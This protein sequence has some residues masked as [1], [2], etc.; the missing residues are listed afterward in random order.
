MRA[1]ARRRALFVQ[2]PPISPDGLPARENHPLGA[3]CVI[4]SALR[5]ERG[6]G[7]E[8][9]ILDRAVADEGSD[10]AILD[11]IERWRPGIL[12]V[13]LYVWNVVR[14]IHMIREARK[15]I[16]D[17]LVV[18]GGP[19]AVAGRPELF[20][21][22]IDIAVPGEG[23][24]AFRAVLEA[25]GAG[26]AGASL[27]RVPGLLLPPP[28]PGAAP[29]FTGP[30]A[31]IVSLDG[32]GSPYLEGWIDAARDRFLYLEATRGCRFH[33]TFC[34]YDADTG[35]PLKSLSLDR[36]EGVLAHAAE[37]EV[38]E[39]FLLDPTLNQ[40]RDARELIRALDRGNPTGRGGRK[41]FRY[42]GELVAEI[43]DPE[44]A[45]LLARAGFHTVESGLQSTNPET[46]RIIQRFHHRE[47]FL[48]GVR[49]LKA[50]GLHVRVD[51]IVGMPAETLESMKRA[52]DFV[53]EEGIGDD[54]QVF[55]LM[56][57][58]GT[59]LAEQAERLGIEHLRRPPYTVLRT[60]TM[61]GDDIAEAVA[62][63]EERLGVSW[64]HHAE[65]RRFRKAEKI[66][67]AADGAW[68][69]ALENYRR[70]FLALDAREL[71]FDRAAEDLRAPLEAWLARSPFA[72]LD[73]ILSADQPAALA[74]LER[75]VEAI[76]PPEWTL[77][78]G[79]Y[80]RVWT[81]IP[82][83][84]RPAIPDEWIDRARGMSL[85]RFER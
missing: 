61:S 37:K 16:P 47:R 11:E 67:A 78:A 66:E 7:W 21:F 49:L 4:L 24:E 22:G 84:A 82:A 18:A 9:R 13:T 26:G 2:L 29:R 44:M 43:V 55:E 65:L 14:S 79:I 57:L 28:R 8:F 5:G 19:E 83:G 52:V 68:R 36:V 45:D 10:R 35:G 17:L 53:A 1:L 42:G 71:P 48:N 34:R 6:R 30:A 23:E 20:D 12:G 41:A 64:T 80:R 75:L 46:L 33:C 70:N 40:R 60:P 63:S 58:P 51:L 62:Y 50:R 74:P 76:Q 38:R 54:V 72:S 81:V 77:G 73:I 69:S 59:V 56:V 3:A 25:L 31:P 39:V 27:E 32:L 85:V 15:L